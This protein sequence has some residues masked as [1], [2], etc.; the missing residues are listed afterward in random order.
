M[1]NTVK[2]D[3]NCPKCG[4]HCDQLSVPDDIQPGPGELLVC[5]RCAGLMVL[6]EGQPLSTRAPTPE[7]TERALQDPEIRLMRSFVLGQV[8][9][10]KVS[11][12]K[13]N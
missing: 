9:G 11:Q 7:E 3:I 12:A 5:G 1:E 6:V 8:S 13:W 4:G 10:R 2:C